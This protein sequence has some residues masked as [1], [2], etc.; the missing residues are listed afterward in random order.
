MDRGMGDNAHLSY[1]SDDSWR[2]ALS[3]WQTWKPGALL[4]ID[5]FGNDNPEANAKALARVDIATGRLPDTAII[6]RLYIRNP[7]DGTGDNHWR[8]LKPAQWVEKHQHFANKRVY[9]SADNEGSF[10]HSLPW[11][12]EVAKAARAANIRVSLGGFSVGAYQP[13]DIPK[14]DA[15]LRYMAAHPGWF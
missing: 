1:L 10:V 13:E 14:A 4:L 8:F 2:E 15:L 11:L 12:L 9:S 5:S 7:H 6:Y 3:R